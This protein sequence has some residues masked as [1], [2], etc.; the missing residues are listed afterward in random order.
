MAEKTI[1]QIPRPV[2]EQYEKGKSAFERQNFDYAVAIFT[3]VLAQEPAFYEC[4][5]ALRAAQSR[6][7]SGATTFFKK[8][9][10]GAGSSPLVAKGQIELMKNPLDALKTAEQI[11]NSDPNSAAGHKL[12]ADAAM[13]AEFPKTAVLSLKIVVKHSP[14]DE[15]S[16][17]EPRPC[18]LR[19]RTRRKGRND[20]LRVDAA[21]S[22]R[23]DT[24]G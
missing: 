16:Q 13:A 12:L 21:A 1:N 24:G 15:E 18:L 19:S 8:V 14:K 22:E 6:K 20:P 7:H 3:Q 9:L 23:P 17:K 10:S 11:L 2:R 4:R 5:E